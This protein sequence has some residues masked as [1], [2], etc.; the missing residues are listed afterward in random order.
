[1]DRK[2]A[3]VSAVRCLR[4]GRHRRRDAVTPPPELQRKTATMGRAIAPFVRRRS[5][6]NSCGIQTA[7]TAATT[8][9]VAQNT[10]KRANTAPGERNSGSAVI[11]TG[12]WQC[13]RFPENIE[14]LRQRSKGSEEIATTPRF[15]VPKVSKSPRR[16]ASRRRL[17]CIRSFQGNRRKFGSFAVL[18]LRVPLS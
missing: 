7:G 14:I 8:G 17:G 5:R 13:R 11:P 3:Q 6:A 10:V 4:G 18:E 12:S 16:E 2:A 1:M 9:R 15:V